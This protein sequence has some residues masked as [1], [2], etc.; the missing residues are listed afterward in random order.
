MIP[1]ETICCFSNYLISYWQSEISCFQLV[2][3]HLFSLLHGRF[4]SSKSFFFSFCCNLMHVSASNFLQS[5][6][7]AVA[8]ALLAAGAVILTLNVLLLVCTF[9]FNCISCTDMLMPICLVHASCNNFPFP[10]FYK[11]SVIS[12]SPSVVLEL[13]LSN[14]GR[15]SIVVLTLDN[16][17]SLWSLF[18]VVT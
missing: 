11:C 15:C 1:Y 10:I 4:P 2:V 17:H 5:E 7:F 12:P 14:E 6:V 13:Y 18:R 8:F 9:G 3:F 16:W